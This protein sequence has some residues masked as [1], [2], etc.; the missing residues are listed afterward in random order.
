MAEDLDEVFSP[1]VDVHDSSRRTPQPCRDRD[2]IA[3]NDRTV[4]TEAEIDGLVREYPGLPSDYLEYLR[5]TGWGETLRGAMIYEGP[6]APQD[7]YG[8]EYDG[9][10]VILLGDDP[11]GYCLAFDLAATQYGELS[12]SGEWTPWEADE[13]LAEYVAEDDDE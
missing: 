7:V 6:M 5:S 8:D 12:D 3:M 1:L 2:P 4:L 9:P 13:T 11:Q 10:D